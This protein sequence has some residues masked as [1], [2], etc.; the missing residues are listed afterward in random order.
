MFS[1]QCAVC[2]ENESESE[3]SQQFVGCLY[4]YSV[5]CAVHSSLPGC[6]VERT[7]EGNSGQSMLF[8]SGKEANLCPYRYLQGIY[9]TQ[10]FSTLLSPSGNLGFG[11]V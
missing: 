11:L 6:Q 7:Y 3:N 4:K 5:Q 8:L 9:I 1:V 10:I 2:S